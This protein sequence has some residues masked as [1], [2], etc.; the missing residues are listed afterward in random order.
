VLLTN[1]SIDSISRKFITRKICGIS[2]KGETTVDRHG[3]AEVGAVVSSFAL[4]G[5]I[6]GEENRGR[7]RGSEAKRKGPRAG[8]RRQERNEKAGV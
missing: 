4:R 7:R 1:N 8:E 5:D 2:D 3:A 6:S